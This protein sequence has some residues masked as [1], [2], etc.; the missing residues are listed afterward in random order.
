MSAP[1]TLQVVDDD[2]VTVFVYRWRPDDPPRAAVQILHGMGEHA[3]RYDYVAR[4]L[5]KA[6]FVVYADDHRASGRTAAEGAGLGNLGPRGM[7]GAVESVH[8]V[9]GLMQ[10]EEPG[11]PIFL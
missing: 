11:L 8:A 7:A 4:T 5:V 10:R 9:T 1:E 3:A 6:G 2:E